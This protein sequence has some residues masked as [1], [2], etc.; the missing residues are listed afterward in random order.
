M[1]EPRQRVPVELA[2]GG[3][4]ED[5]RLAGHALCGGLVLKVEPIVQ[6]NV[7]AAGG[8]EGDQE[9]QGRRHQGKDNAGQLPQHRHLS[10]YSDGVFSARTFIV[11]LGLRPW[12]R[13]V[14]RSIGH[15][16]T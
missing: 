16:L 4:G 5:N 15:R 8:A 6:L 9:D 1:A 13:E 10:R 2:D 7:A 14:Y 3:E 11:H 12:L